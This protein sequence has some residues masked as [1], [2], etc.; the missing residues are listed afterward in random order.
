[1]YLAFKRQ[2]IHALPATTNNPMTDQDHSSTTYTPAISQSKP[3]LSSNQQRSP[4]HHRKSNDRPRSFIVDTSGH[5]PISMLLHS[6]PLSTN[7]SSLAISLQQY[8]YNAV[9]T[10][11]SSL[12]QIST[13]SKSRPIIQQTQCRSINICPDLQDAYHQHLRRTKLSRRHQFPNRHLIPIE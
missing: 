11:C 6:P 4:G 7:H 5:P 13:P 12:N 1:M 2:K 8:Q 3:A 9:Q 10:T